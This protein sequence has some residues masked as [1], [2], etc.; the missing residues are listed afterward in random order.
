MY[1]DF[2]VIFSSKTFKKTANIRIFNAFFEKNWAETTDG[3]MCAGV[4]GQTPGSKGGV[5]YGPGAGRVCADRA[6]R[7]NTVDPA[8]FR[9]WSGGVH[10]IVCSGADAGGTAGKRRRSAQHAA[11]SAG[12]AQ[13]PGAELLI[14]AEDRKIHRFGSLPTTTEYLSKEVI[15]FSLQVIGS[16]PRTFSP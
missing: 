2:Q 11:S 15:S 9:P 3:K 10:H 5:T 14:Y 6:D 1:A 8:A 7:L 13:G 12:Y 4:F 16:N